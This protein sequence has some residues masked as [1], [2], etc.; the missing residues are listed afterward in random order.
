MIVDI[1]GGELFVARESG[2]PDVRVGDHVTIDLRDAV[3]HVFDVET[4]LRRG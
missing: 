2:F 1:G 4:G 3:R